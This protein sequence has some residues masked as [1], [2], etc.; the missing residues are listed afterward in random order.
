MCVCVLNVVLK[1]KHQLGKAKDTYNNCG[2]ATFDCECVKHPRT[3]TPP[4][5]THTHTH[6]QTHI[7]HI[8][9]FT[10]RASPSSRLPAHARFAEAQPDKTAPKM[11]SL[12][13]EPVGEFGAHTSCWH[14]WAYAGSTSHIPPLPP[15]SFCLFHAGQAH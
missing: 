7:S 1:R 11:V 9:T 15:S 14:G 8:N 13:I 10:L 4:T 2:S 6:K 12:K 3:P 5:N